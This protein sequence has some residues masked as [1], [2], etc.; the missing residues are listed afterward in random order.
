MTTD[1]PVWPAAGYYR[2]GSRSN[3]V[4]PYYPGVSIS[5]RRRSGLRLE[6][7]W[8]S[9][10]DGASVSARCRL[11][12]RYRNLV[13]WVLIG[14]TLVTMAAWYFIGVRST[15]AYVDKAVELLLIICLV[16][17]WLLARKGGA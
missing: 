16:L 17:D 7:P 12:G 1:A 9:R 10:I 3:G 13:R 4:D 11:L 15:I 6:R 2:T 5:R 14:Y 8:L